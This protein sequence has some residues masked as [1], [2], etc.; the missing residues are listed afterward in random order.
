MIFKST[1]IRFLLLYGLT[2]GSLSSL[3][4][5]SKYYFLVIDHAIELYILL[6]AVVFVLVGVW[7]GLRWS[8]P[9]VIE[10]TT[11]VPVHDPS[12]MHPSVQEELD[13]L[14]I[15]SRELEVLT[16]LSRGLSNE[17]IADRL[18]VSTNTVKTH[19]ANLYAKLD[20]KRRTQAVEKARTLG[21]I[22]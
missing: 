15:S 10:K 9:L 16:Q 20:V 7:I 2:L 21:L 18:F 4:M 1:K 14:G 5:W 19:L 12:L 3:M 6:I 17:E 8:A 22:R 11:L 13:R